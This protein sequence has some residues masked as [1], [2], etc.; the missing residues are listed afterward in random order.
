MKIETDEFGDWLTIDGERFGASEDGEFEV[1]A[2]RICKAHLADAPCGCSIRLCDR[3]IGS[4]ELTSRQ[5]DCVFEHTVDDLLIAR[6][7]SPF[8]VDDDTISIPARQD[9]LR[10]WI[11]AARRSFEP[12]LSDGTVIRL[13]ETI[14]EEIAYL[15]YAVVMQNQTFAD[16][17][18]FVEALEARIPDGLA[19]P[20][21][22]ICH[23]SEDKS[24][25][26]HLVEEL[27]RRALHGWYDRRE[28]LVGDSIVAK[29]NEGLANARFL[30]AVLSPAS[31]V[32]PWV[33]KELN[34]TL[35]R[36]LAQAEVVILPVLIANCDLPPLLADLKYADFRQSFDHGLEDLVAAI[37]GWNRR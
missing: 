10:E 5:P 11:V 1:L 15:E 18:M 14:L 23:A 26:D 22:F 28:I 7:V 27:D 35:M 29:V 13:E 9:L 36:Q 21:L 33:T 6:A 37:R 20:L 8:F 25:V 2:S 34:S 16:A 17:E 31:V 12:L 4:S 32:K 30:V 24:T 19:R 3:V